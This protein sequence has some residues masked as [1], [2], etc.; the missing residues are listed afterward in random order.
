M[1]IYMACSITQGGHKLQR[2]NIMAA[3]LDGHNEQH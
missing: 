1:K 3:L 2:Q